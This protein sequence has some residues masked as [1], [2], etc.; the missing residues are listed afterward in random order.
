AVYQLRHALLQDHLANV[1]R[2]NHLRVR[3]GAGD[4]LAAW[5]LV[6]LLFRQGRIDEAIMILQAQA[7]AD[8]GSAVRRLAGLLAARGQV[9]EAIAV[10]RILADAGDWFAA[11]S[12]AGLLAGQC[13][14]DELR[15]RADAG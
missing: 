14:V 11:K 1:V 10:L 7:G 12:L 15:V 9:D 5:R 4:G 13:Q 6:D 2:D 8:D 3:A